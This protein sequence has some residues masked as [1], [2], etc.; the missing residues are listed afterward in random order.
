MIKKILVK[1]GQVMFPGGSNR[2]DHELLAKTNPS[3]KALQV[4]LYNKWR[5]DYEA[6]H[7]LPKLEH[8]GMR[9]FSQLEEDGLLL[10]IF[11]ILGMGNR[12][13]VDLGAADG[14]NSNCANLALNWGWEGLFVDGDGE[15]IDRGKSFYAKHPDTWLY[16]PKFC[17]EFIKTENV[18][19]ILERNSVTGEIEFLNIDIDGNDYWIWDAIKA[20]DP[21]V[22]MVETHVEFGKEPITVAYDPDYV[23]PPA[24]HPQYFGAGP[25]ALEKLARKKGYRLVGSNLYGFNTIY[26]KEGLAEDVFPTVTVDSILKHPRNKERH[27]LFEPIKDWDYIRV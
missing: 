16:P 6:G 25:T 19:D 11:S 17:C 24:R 13:F 3:L 7:P 15:Q 10:Y 4:S 27:Q 21:K 14:I 5:T 1:L 23:Y 2:I 12:R 26:I 22:V 9:I 18:N 20:V 8:T